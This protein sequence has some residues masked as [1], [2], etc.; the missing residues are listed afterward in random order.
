MLDTI[1]VKYP[2]SPDQEELLYWDYRISSSPKGSRVSYI[3]NP[4]VTD[5]EVMLKYTY[6]PYD[7]NGNRLLN[8]EFSLPKLLYG[9]NYQMIGSIDGTI[10]L[11]NMYL[12]TVPHAPILD[13]AEGILNRLHMCYN[14]FVGSAVDDLLNAIGYL[15]YPHR[16]TKYHKYEGA[17]FRAKHIT[18]KFYNKERET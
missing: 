7:Y 18:T 1:R 13:L 12:A 6:I 2:I 17:E 15:D 10:K 5:D 4:R 16:R 14:H 11:A 9:N 8:L 3:Y